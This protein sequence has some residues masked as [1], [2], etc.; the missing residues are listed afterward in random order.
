MPELLA[1]LIYPF[2]G[3]AYFAGRPALWKYAAAAVAI[4]LLAF[5][6]VLAVVLHYRAGIVEG[7]TPERFPHWL[8]AAEGGVLSL[9]LVVAALFA[10]FLIGNLLSVPVLDALTERI[11]RDLGETLPPGR[12]WRHALRRSLINQT[13]KLLIFGAVQVGLLLLYVTPLAF[14]HLPISTV[15]GVLF[16][17]Y[18]Y[19]DYPLDARRVPVPSRFA[20]MLRHAGATLGYGGVM[21]LILLVPLL[22]TALLPLTV[23]GAALLAHRLDSPVRTG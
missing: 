2:R 15:L 17:G 5:A 23:A 14:L 20:W 19:L 9:L 22:G 13:L 11:L 16:L 21:F 18:D 8:R 7:V 1:G 12:G 3:V 10:A 4:H 6:A